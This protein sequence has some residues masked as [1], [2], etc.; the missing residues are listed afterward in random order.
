MQ[1]K[2]LKNSATIAA[3]GSGSTGAK[4][5]VMALAIVGPLGIDLVV[6][7]IPRLVRDIAPLDA[8]SVFSFYLLGLA[9]GQIS[10]AILL[11][12]RF[13]TATFLLGL[14][15]YLCAAMALGALV[16]D[17][18][19]LL[20]M[21]L[22]SGLG[23]GILYFICFSMI[24]SASDKGQISELYAQRSLA[25]IIS[26][27]AAP[28]ISSTLLIFFSWHSVFIFQLAYGMGL[29]FFASDA[30]TIMRQ[31]N[32]GESSNVAN[33]RFCI[34]GMVGYVSF[35]ILMYLTISSLPDLLTKFGV[36]SPFYLS[37]F[38]LVAAACYQ[39]G[40]LVRKNILKL[41]T[42]RIFLPAVFFVIFLIFCNVGGG[43]AEAIV[44]LCA[45]YIFSGLFQSIQASDL[46]V[47]A[48]FKKPLWVG[49][50]TAFTLACCF[51]CIELIHLGPDWVAA[52]WT[53]LVIALV[54]ICMSFDWLPDE[55][56]GG[57]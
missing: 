24:S 57:V 12:F 11:H 9:I 51:A 3:D 28:V 31:F 38:V 32:S 43:A 7:A 4:R 33:Q 54:A 27:G 39:I 20:L 2:T 48:L 6:P 45:L 53:A 10:C 22:L 47:H 41:D 16:N 37:G 50:L 49:A 52:F 42:R 5:A 1:G 8:H 46:L 21:R 25:L 23:A 14:T 30:I 55:R 35:S 15:C 19:M 18:Y 40:V 17:I 29:C 36:Q 13:F 26:V 44:S 34:R 56:L